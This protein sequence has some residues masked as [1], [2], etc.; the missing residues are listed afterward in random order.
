MQISEQIG[1]FRRN[2]K[3]ILK[4]AMLEHVIFKRGSETTDHTTTGTNSGEKHRK[5]NYQNVIRVV[6]CFAFIFPRSS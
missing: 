1:I 2:N 6:I 3:F 4:L 5:L